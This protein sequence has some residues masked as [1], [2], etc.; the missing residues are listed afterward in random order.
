MKTDR[1]VTLRVARGLAEDKGKG[2]V[3]LDHADMNR[4]DLQPGSVVEVIGRRQTVAK[5]L[6]AFAELSGSGL[7]QMD[8]L[9]RKKRPGWA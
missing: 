1:S 2:I 9:I 4:L 5:V 7:I 8:G 3:R 6:P